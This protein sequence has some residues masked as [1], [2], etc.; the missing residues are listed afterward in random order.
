MSRIDPEIMLRLRESVMDELPTAGA[1]VLLSDLLIAV[2]RKLKSSG[3]MKEGV[4]K[5][6]MATAIKYLRD[7]KQIAS[8]NFKNHQVGY[9]RTG[10]TVRR[11]AN[12]RKRVDPTDLILPTVKLH[13]MEFTVHLLAQSQFSGC[14][15]ELF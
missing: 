8:V 1:H 7:R 10:N 12:T 9:F 6:R 13:P 11:M 3:V 15:H 2:T 5:Q 14:R 4:S